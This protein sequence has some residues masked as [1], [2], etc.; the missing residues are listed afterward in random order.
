[1]FI[2]C[3][4]FMKNIIGLNMII[5]IMTFYYLTPLNFILTLPLFLLLNHNIFFL[6]VII[7]IYTMEHN[8]KRYINY[9]LLF[10]MSLITF[11]YVILFHIDIS[12]LINIIIVI[13]IHL[14]KYNNMGDEGGIKTLS[15]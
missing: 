4:F 7:L 15:K 1:M 6:F 8:I 2:L 3:D 12:Y 5:Y 10:R 13:I 9:N 14:S 11:Y